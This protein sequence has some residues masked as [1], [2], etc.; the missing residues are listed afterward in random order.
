MIAAVLA[1]GAPIFADDGE[2]SVKSNTVQIKSFDAFMQSS[3]IQGLAETYK[4][5]RKISDDKKKKIADKAFEIVKTEDL[6]PGYVF[7]SENFKGSGAA[8]KAVRRFYEIHYDTAKKMDKLEAYDNFLRMF[9][10]A[11]ADLIKKASDRAY[12]IELDIAKSDVS[13]S[14]LEAAAQKLYVTAVR[15]KD[16]DDKFIFCRKY[17][18]ILNEDIF[19]QARATF[20][21]MRDKE[22]ASIFQDISRRLNSIERSIDEQTRML[23]RKLTILSE[24]MESM[25]DKLGDINSNISENSDY[26]R[27]VNRSVQDQT[28]RWKR[29]IDKKKGFFDSGF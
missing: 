17:N 27:E 28:K 14:G 21:L 8:E 18:I 29:H 19:V 2:M 4:G 7:I 11:P 16:K 3:D 13:R 9:P 1:L 10:E 25:Q 23:S 15:A 24:S 12:R 6:I 20:D 22:M 26:V 5:Q